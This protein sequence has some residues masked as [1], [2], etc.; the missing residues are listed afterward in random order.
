MQ[1]FFIKQFTRMDIGQF[2]YSERISQHFLNFATFIHVVVSDLLKATRALAVC[3][4]T[5]LLLWNRAINE[6]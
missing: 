4:K 5:K 3:V 2:T 6:T 1:A